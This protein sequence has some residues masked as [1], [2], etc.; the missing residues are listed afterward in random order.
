MRITESPAWKSVI[1]RWTAALVVVT[2][3]FIGARFLAPSH[4]DTALVA[5]EAETGAI[6][7]PAVS[8][9]S[10]DASGG[11]AVSFMPASSGGDAGC[12]LNSIPAPCI[13][14]ATTAASGWGTPIFSDDF[15]GTSLNKTVWDDTWFSG[16]DVNNVKTSASNVAVQDG[17]LVLTLQSASSGALVGTNPA[18]GTNQGFEFTT[19]YAEARVYFPGT[20]STI[21]NWPAWWT[22]SQNW[23]ATGEI[24]IAEGLGTLTSNYHSNAGA[25]NSNTIPGT[26][27][28]A[29]HIYAVNRQA[30]K[31]D[32]YWDGK[33]VR[34]YV[35]DDNNAPHYLI[36]NAGSDGQVFSGAAGAVKVDYVRVWKKQ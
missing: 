22:S 11:E 27:S 5:G 30:G 12:S 18:D 25:N 17:D 23:P 16:S 29:Y 1:T 10:T 6:T 33:L 24:D 31:N 26:W 9:P 13:G 20:G 34:S 7:E 35:T 19:G 2:V 8:V 28:N 32:I 15:N 36:F 3:G 14:S 4:A 21:Y